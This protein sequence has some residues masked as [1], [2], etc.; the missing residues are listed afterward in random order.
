RHRAIP[1]QIKILGPRRLRRPHSVG[2]PRIRATLKRCGLP[3]GLL[4]GSVQI[5]AKRRRFNIPAELARGLMAPKRDDTDTFTLRTLPLSVIPRP[6]H[7]EVVVVR[8]ALPGMTK[9]LPW[10][11]RV[12]LIPKPGNIQVG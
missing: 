10:S 4:A 12:F 7:D 11:P 1:A 9:N 6:R 2:M 8:I 3:V 5:V